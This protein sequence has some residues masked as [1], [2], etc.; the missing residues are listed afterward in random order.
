[1]TD[2]PTGTVTF[3][4]TDMEGSTRLLQELGE[5]YRAVQDQH[6]KILRGAIDA[7]EGAEIRTEGDS[8]FVS[9]RTPAQAVRAAVEA[10]RRLAGSDWPHGR[11]L[12][13]RMGL[14]TGEG[15]LGGGDYVGIDVN[16]AARIAAAGHGGQI[17]ISDA[18][19]ALVEHSV[20]EGVSIRDLGTH[21]LKDIEHPEHLHDLVVD[22][23][24]AD[25]PPIRTL[26]AR[27]TNLP[28]ERTSFVGREREMARIGELLETSRLLTLTGP[29]GTGKTRLALKVAAHQLGGF[30]DGVFLVDLSTISDPLLVTSAMAAAVGVREDPG[31]EL[32]ESLIDHLRE[33]QLL[34]VLDNFE[35]VVD[36]APAVDRLLAAA[37]G[38]TVLATSRT[39]LRLSAEQE[40]Q[41]PPLAL[42]DATRPEDLV[43]LRT[44]E[45][46]M[47]F[48]E[49][50]SAVRPGFRLTEA[51]AP[52]V[53]EIVARLDGL[54]LALELAASRVKVL[55]PSELLDRLGRRLPVLTGGARDLPE[56]Q[57]TLRAA[58]EWSHDLLDAEE[59]HLFARLA[60][61][62][63]G[64][65]LDAVEAVCG[66]GLGIDVLDGLTTLVDNSL[67]RQG[68]LREDGTRFRMLET[69]REFAADR[70]SSSGQEEEVRRRHAEHVRDL[71]EEAEPHLLGEGQAE[72]L[73]RLE[74][75]HDNVRAALDWAEA[76]GD[77]E[78]ALR[79]AS[80][81]WRF[82]QLHSH[83]AEG[84]AR[85]ERILALPGAEIRGAPRARALG[86]LGGLRYWQNDYEA[87]Q[88][89]YEEAVEIARELG[90]PRL[91]AR[92]L[93][94]LSFVPLVTTQDFDR[95]LQLLGEALDHTPDDDL[96]LRGQILTGFAY[97]PTFKGENP[98]DG[99]ESI[100]RA[101]AIHRKL[102]DR[103][104]T[105]ENLT[106]LASLK[107]LSGETEA[108][109]G[110][111][112]EAV[113]ILVQGNSPMMLAMALTSMAFLK[114][115][116]GDH[117][118]TARFLG[119]WSRIKDEGG[120][121]PPPFALRHFG[122]PEGDARRALGD[123]AFKRIHSEG[124]AMTMDEAR[125]YVTEESTPDT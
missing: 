37:P 66:T 57:R 49:R 41:V 1:V 2:P 113:E 99:I 96:V 70:L 30:P 12:G 46:V 40:Y 52:S 91:L 11:P 106:G 28:A 60:V 36:A 119:A 27:R 20:P 15:V 65:S 77:A 76:T 105:A 122:D 42:P 73:T 45:S 21:R 95:Q 10:Q 3:L 94:D 8:F 121:S 90:E 35:Q 74:I 38:L 102:G 17:L 18:T 79:T 84:R 110:L 118:R 88:A 5:G 101:L 54:P 19:R 93:F 32:L 55:S 6:Q 56:R 71:A 78:T 24:P 81:I 83:L 69:I 59:Q 25:F 43:A 22:G 14:H 111:L 72:W 123:E 64:W 103:M 112:R 87:V 68:R 85:L 44:C 98:A 124:Y 107:L 114:N 33:R 117:Q 47:L 23:L 7:E 16:R 82:W 120:A 115:A 109:W 9:F 13:V 89:P 100:E 4:F 61:F 29:G 26:D 67:V 125:S 48:V 108:G 62:A 58:I 34:L 31:R 53:S 104:L 75:E 116:Q 92:A 39:P 50:A 51:I 80:A 63:G 97:L 86:A